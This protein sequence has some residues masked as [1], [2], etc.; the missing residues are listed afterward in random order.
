MAAQ[1]YGIAFA[2][3]VAQINTD[4]SKFGH[5]GS[6]QTYVPYLGMIL[7]GDHS[8]SPFNMEEPNLYYANQALATYKMQN[9][10]GMRFTANVDSDAESDISID[11]LVLGE[12]EEFRWVPISEIDKFD[13]IGKMRE[14]LDKFVLQTVR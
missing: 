10:N 8:N 4:R 3:E 9:S 2:D 14:C 7:K 11:K 6:T 5:S 1:T 12:G 13:L